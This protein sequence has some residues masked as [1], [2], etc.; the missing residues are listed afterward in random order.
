LD[1]QRRLAG[2]NR[3]LCKLAEANCRA[4]EEQ[5]VQLESLLGVINGVAEKQHHAREKVSGLQEA[6]GEVRRQINQRDEA[7]ERGIGPLEQIALGLAEMKYR[8]AFLMDSTIDLKGSSGF[9]TEI[10]PFQGD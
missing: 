4:K 1:L 8:D 10:A 6:R 2:Q 7:V 5:D 9:I 3:E